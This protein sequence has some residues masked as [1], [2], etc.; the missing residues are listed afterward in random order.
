M[1]ILLLVVRLK[2]VNNIRQSLSAIG[3][4]RNRSDPARC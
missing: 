4:V 2:I 1:L 3:D